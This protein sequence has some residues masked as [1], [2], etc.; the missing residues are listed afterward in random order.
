MIG[1]ITGSI[2]IGAAAAAVSESYLNSSLEYQD[3]A[4]GGSPYQTFVSSPAKP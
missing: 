2:V 1:F 3:G 4:M